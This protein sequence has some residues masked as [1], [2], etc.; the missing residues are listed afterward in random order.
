MPTSVKELPAQK[1]GRGRKVR[2]EYAELV[3]LSVPMFEK[4]TKQVEYSADEVEAVLGGMTHNRKGSV[5][6]VSEASKRAG[7]RAAAERI[8]LGKGKH[9]G[10]TLKATFPNDT[11]CI[12]LA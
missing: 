9:K 12:T 5:V 8:T 6:D 3:S 11:V 1:G 4:G 10:S 2:P 7:V